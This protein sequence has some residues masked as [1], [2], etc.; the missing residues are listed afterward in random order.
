MVISI[1]F[2]LFEDTNYKVS[3]GQIEYLNNSSHLMGI[4]SSGPDC[5]RAKGFGYY[6]NVT[7]Y[8][9]WIKD[10]IADIENKGNKN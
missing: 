2:K 1:V 3:L 8:L 6:T 5:V 10:K 7:A 4:V 9:D